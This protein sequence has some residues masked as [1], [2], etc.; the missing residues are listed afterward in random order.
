MNIRTYTALQKIAK[1]IV[2]NKV[3][4]PYNPLYREE[5]TRLYTKAGGLSEKAT[6][7]S[8]ALRY[9]PW[10]L[11]I[12]GVAGAGV[13]AGIYGYHKDKD[14][15]QEALNNELAG[16]KAEYDRQRAAIPTSGFFNKLFVESSRQHLDSMQDWSESRARMRAHN[17]RNANAAG[18]AL[19][20]SGI[21][22]GSLLALALA[23]KLAADAQK[24]DKKQI[25]KELEDLG[26]LDFANPYTT[27]RLKSR[28][29]DLAAVDA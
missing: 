15:I 28:L 25:N 22:A 20:A 7:K 5:R 27:A 21:T 1:G 12:G 11:G 14:K 19:S 18:A 24:L 13:L 3:D 2:T 8:V 17:E 29:N 23:G 6:K 16:I 26:P 9:L 4:A 10:L